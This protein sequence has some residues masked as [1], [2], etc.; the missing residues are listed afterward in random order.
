M[1]TQQRAILQNA[2]LLLSTGWTQHAAARDEQG[3]PI[4][5][6]SPRA[7]V[8]CLVAAIQRSAETIPS[9]NRSDRPQLFLLLGF[10]AGEREAEQWNEDPTRT[11]EDVLAR[12]DSAL[13][14]P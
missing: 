11:Q 12:L 7:V 9:F 8:F 2:R 14:Q 5:A 4:S 1:T 10:P 13:A 6:N 3:V